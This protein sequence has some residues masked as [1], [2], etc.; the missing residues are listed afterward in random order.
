[1]HLCWGERTMTSEKVGRSARRVEQRCAS[2]GE[3]G[4]IA[5][6]VQRVRSDP[7]AEDAAVDQLSPGCDHKVIAVVL[8]G[9]TCRFGRF[10]A[11]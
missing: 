8:L 10:V 9:K 4:D 3:Q 7:P 11:V 6:P 1:M 2:S 5:E